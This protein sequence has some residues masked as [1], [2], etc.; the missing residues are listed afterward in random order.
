[1]SNIVEE[2]VR[3]T[4]SDL[5]LLPDNGLRYEIIDGE[6]LVSKSP[7]WHHQTTCGEI[8]SAL[9][10]WSRQSNL[11]R[12][13]LSP[14]II[15]GDEDNVV[16]DVVWAS[17]QRLA[18]LMDSAGHLTGAP[19][20]VV[21]VLSL[22]AENERR[23]CE[24]KLKLYAARGV[25]EYW[26]VDWRLQQVEIHRREKATL[27]LVATLLADDELTSPL[28]PTFAAPVRQFFV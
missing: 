20:L 12:A 3:W 5:M 17:H 25:Q 8:Y 9:S 1:M 15:F 16:P 14:G 27:R 23:D 2:R 4:T 6:L 19:E 26:I 7:H 13:S 10:V 18:V 28:L 21:E 24:A 11:G 22:G